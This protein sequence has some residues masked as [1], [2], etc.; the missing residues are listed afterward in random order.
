VRLELLG[1]LKNPM[2]SS[3]IEPAT[4][5]LLVNTS[6]NYATTCPIWTL[7]VGN[8]KRQEKFVIFRVIKS[9]GKKI[10]GNTAFM[11]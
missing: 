4:F 8:I 7:E 5:R 11:E 10:I 1:K 9:R 2:V 6:T 3:E